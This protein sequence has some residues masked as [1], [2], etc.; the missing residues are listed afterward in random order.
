M[1]NKLSLSE[2]VEQAVQYACVFHQGQKD[3]ANQPFILHIMRVGLGCG[4]DPITQATGFLHDIVED[5]NVTLAD[6]TAVGF[7]TEVVA[8]VDAMTRRPGETYWTYLDRLIQNPVALKV[9]KVDLLDNLRPDRQ[10]FEGAESLLAR[11]SKA[12]SIVEAALGEVEAS[13][14]A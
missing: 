5:S 6:L 8:A 13:E 4:P 3:K 12:L 9:K 1:L 10:D 7:P 2:I 14:A 11:H